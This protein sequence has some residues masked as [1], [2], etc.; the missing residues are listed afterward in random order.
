MP[1]VIAFF[2]ASFILFV[3]AVNA[4][5]HA[6]REANRLAILQS[7]KNAI[8]AKYSAVDKIKQPAE[9][10]RLKADLEAIDR[11]ISRVHPSISRNMSAAINKRAHPESAPQAAEVPPRKITGS[12]EYAAW[13]VF[14]NFETKESQ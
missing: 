14:K 7:E 13:D 10:G 4:R 9:A 5:E 2:A 11:E 6:D 1:F 12:G 3:G 8:L